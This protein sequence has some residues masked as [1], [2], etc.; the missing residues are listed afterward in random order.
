MD[1]P[2]YEMI[3]TKDIKKSLADFSVKHAIPLFKCSYSIEHLS[4]YIKTVNDDD[5]RLFNENLS[6][7]Y[8]DKEELINQHVELN[9]IYTISITPY[10]EKILNLKYSLDIEKNSYHPKI[11]ISPESHIPYKKLKAQETFNLLVD[12]INKIKAENNILIDVFDD[13]MI[14]NLK[15]FTK[16]LH[17]G[18]FKKKIRIPLFD[19]LAPESIATA[20]LELLFQKKKNTGEKKHQIVE[21]AKDEVIV[22][23]QKPKFGRNGFTAYGKQTSQDYNTNKEDL[24]VPIDDSTIYIEEDDD[25]KLYKSKIKGFVHLTTD[26][27]SVKTKFKRATLSRMDASISTEEDNNIEV[28]IS[29]YDTTQDSI[30]VGVQLKSETI[31][32]NG[33][34]GAN[35][36]LEALNLQIDGATHVSSNQFAKTAIINRHKG[37]L[38]CNDAKIKLLEGGVV[39][40]TNLEVESSLGGTIYAQDVTIGQVKNNLKVYASHSISIRLVSGEDNFFTIGYQNIPIINSKVNFLEEEI[41][42]LKISLEEAKLHDIQKVEALQNTMKLLKVEINEI[43][44]SALTAKITIEKA[45]LGLNTIKFTLD[46]NEELSYKTQARSYSP[47]HL[48]TTEDKIILRPV[49][50]SVALKL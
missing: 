23:F 5:F 16:H 42:E 40:A 39:H 26:L 3:K 15:A 34:V 50:T 49:N 13:S 17:Q 32:I 1:T 36:T 48:E 9:Q 38:R 43:K 18:K 30:G 10:K 37:T 47:F 27:L 21:V 44:E 46:N 6:E 8:K 28:N 41:E 12:E 19:G 29:Q 14:R 20:K 22:K 25:K 4:S 11:I 7:H 35:S 45:F 33:H 31:H 2:V 24:Q